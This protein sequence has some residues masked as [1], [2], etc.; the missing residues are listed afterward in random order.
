M[1]GFGRLPVRM[2]HD[3]AVQSAVPRAPNAAATPE[4]HTPR[5][6]VSAE[7]PPKRAPTLD[8][9]LPQGRLLLVV[10]DEQLAE[11]I[12]RAATRRKFVVAIADSAE[13]ARALAV[14]GG[15]N[16][17]VIDFDDRTPDESQA[18]ALALREPFGAEPCPLVVVARNP[19]YTLRMAA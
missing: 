14:E 19:D 7:G 15:F 8:T 1:S 9:S 13:Q 6:T 11:D 2:P 5:E 12:A 3:P 17:L 4:P 10:Q 18:L 16:C